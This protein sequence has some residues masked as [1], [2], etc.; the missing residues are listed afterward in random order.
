MIA[1]GFTIVII[2]CSLYLLIEVPEPTQ[3]PSSS[4]PKPGLYWEAEAVIGI[5]YLPIIGIVLLVLYVLRKR[6]K[7]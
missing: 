7:K 5:T 1:V 3:S 4:E 2:L 6:K